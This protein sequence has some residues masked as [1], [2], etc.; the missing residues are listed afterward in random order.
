MTR[1]LEIIFRVQPE[2]ETK[3]IVYNKAADEKPSKS[4]RQ[5]EH[6]SGKSVHQKQQKPGVMKLKGHNVGAVMEVNKSSAGYRLGGETLKKKETED[7]GDVDGY[8]HEDKKTGTKKKPPISAFMNSNF[9]SVNNSLLFDSSCQHRDPGLHLSFP[10]A[11]DGGG[12]VVDGD[13]SYKP[14]LRQ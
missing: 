7:D 4:N 8:G 9:Q 5:S 11:A 12:A 10:N 3:G 2:V 6:G 13:K 1:L 14:K